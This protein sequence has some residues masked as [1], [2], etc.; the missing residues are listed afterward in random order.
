MK[1]YMNLNGKGKWTYFWRDKPLKKFRK[2][3]KKSERKT[4]KED[5]KQQIN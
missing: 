2:I 5:I 4:S 3:F 1:P